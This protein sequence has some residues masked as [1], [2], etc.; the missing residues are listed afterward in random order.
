[1]K[2]PISW[3]KDM[4]SI[5]ISAEELAHKMTMAGLEAEKIERI[6]AEWEADKVLVGEVLNVT[7]HPD[8]DRLVLAEVQAGTNHLTVVTGAPNITT[9]QKVVL[10]LAG[11]R[12][13]DAY[14]DEPG[15]MK[16]LKPGKIRGI[17]SEGMVCSE[18][19][20]GISDEHEG[21]LVLPEDAP[22]GTPL[23]EYLGDTVIEFEITPNLVHAF[24]I[25]GLAGEAGA[26]LDEP[27]RE[28]AIA[29]MDDVPVQENL[30]R[31]DAPELC[32]RYIG[33]IIDGVHVEPSPNWLTRRLTAAGVRPVNNLVDV[34]NY[35]MLE[36]GQPLHAFDLRNVA[37]ER[38]I[39][40]TAADG[41]R[42]ETLDH[43]KRTFTSEDLLITDAEKPVA[44]AGIMGGVNSEVLDDTTGILLESANF[45]MVNVR[46]TAR[47]LKLRTDASARFERGLD[48]NL[49]W[50]AAMRAVQLIL[51]LCPNANIRCYEDEYPTKKN[52]V[53]IS[54]SFDRIESTLGM[55][56]P[57][58]TVSSVLSRLGF[59][60]QIAD[61]M[62]NVTVPTNRSDVTMREDVI[63][64][65]ARIVG[66]DQL[67]ATLPIGETPVVERDAMFLL[68]RAI[69]ESIVGAGAYEGRSY[70]TVSESA[71]ATWA[72]LTREAVT[73]HNVR[74][75]NPMNDEQPL[76]RTSLLPRLIDSVA[77]NLKHEKSVRLFE[78]GHIFFGTTPDELPDEPSHLA[79]A[80]TGYREPF[81]RFAP[82]VRKMNAEQ[83]AAQQ[84]DFFDVKGVLETA[85]NRA[86]AH[87][88]AY[89]AAQHPALHPGRTASVNHMGER[90]GT[91]GE[92][93]PDLSKELGISDTRLV[94]AEIDLQ[95][96]QALIGNEKQTISVDHFLPVE[97]D[98]A[99]LV[100][101]T[102]PATDV[103][104][105]LRR[106]AGPL[107]TDIMLFDVFEGEQI[108][109]DKKSLAYRLTF[110]APDRALTDAELEKQRVKIQK[111]VKALVGG[112]LR[113]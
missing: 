108:G 58:A 85:L 35:V 104:Q 106:N 68:E 111:G 109:A 3:L 11:A 33:V 2:A 36:L 110:T 97:Q 65:V 38:I 87:E 28:V 37:G 57:E 26:I 51:E 64:E 30:V 55:P 112:E 83:L 60:P 42:M 56:I 9:G 31:I 71:Q 39:V 17:M 100:D 73:H 7:Q 45:N 40:R 6:G 44:V 50:N 53:S 4:V 20:L 34:T 102:V 93:R 81:T 12:L 98:F 107:L 113:A 63:E 94:V 82:Q 49:T 62:V 10:A 14:A 88:I 1:M 78:I 54:F 8:A 47:R 95:A 16:T 90:I 70:V 18:K 91:I 32:S 19:E 77:E 27:V 84:L 72:G 69:R 103:E 76:L 80:F 24:S 75:I 48:P 29:S 105:A 13:V 89:V 66:Y 23:Q 52:P 5:E 21:I 46:H 22:A 43:T 15:K 86:G 74:L 25:C 41:E 101:K 61:G 79:I 67:P 59:Q 99:F 92:V 96:L